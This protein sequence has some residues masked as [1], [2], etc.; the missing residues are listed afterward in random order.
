[1]QKIIPKHPLRRRGR[2]HSAQV[3]KIDF[4]FSGWRRRH[5][6]PSTKL[7]FQDLNV[8]AQVSSAIIISSFE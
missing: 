8:L 5:S 4:L 2:D 1:M 7:G 3:P 6:P